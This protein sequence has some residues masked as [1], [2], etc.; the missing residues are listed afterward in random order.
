MGFKRSDSLRIQSTNSENGIPSQ[1]SR[2]WF[3]LKKALRD[4]CI[5]LAVVEV[6]NKL[7]INSFRFES[8]ELESDL[9]VPKLYRVHRD[10]LDVDQF[11]MYVLS[12]YNNIREGINE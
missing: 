1:G 7:D 10:E 3:E 2:C 4:T 6:L 9:A 5:K 8:Y 12:E 11:V